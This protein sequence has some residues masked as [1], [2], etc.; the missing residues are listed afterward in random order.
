MTWHSG[1]LIRIRNKHEKSN[2]VL[3]F[4]CVWLIILGKTG[5]EHEKSRTYLKPEPE[6]ENEFE[7]TGNILKDCAAVLV[8]TR[9]NRVRT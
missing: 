6:C 4:G 8:I 3:E 9:E 2:Y 7:K 1:I 5:S